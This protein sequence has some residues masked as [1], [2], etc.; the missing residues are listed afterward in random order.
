MADQEESTGPV[1]IYMAQVMAKPKAMLGIQFIG[2]NVQAKSVLFPVLWG[3]LG[4]LIAIPAYLVIHSIL[5]LVWIPIFIG[6]LSVL[7]TM[8]TPPGGEKSFVA[9]VWIWVR[10]QRG[11]TTVEGMKTKVYLD[12]ALLSDPEDGEFYIESPTVKVAEGTVDQHGLFI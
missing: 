5:I 7:V 11:H 9:W 6:L 8:A 3:V 1:L 2:R 12:L 10:G 4:F